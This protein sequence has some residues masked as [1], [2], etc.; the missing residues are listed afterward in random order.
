MQLKTFRINDIA[1]KTV[2][3]RVDYNV[4][5]TK[6]GQV[7]NDRRIQLSLEALRFILLHQAK[8]ILVSHLGR[9]KGPDPKYSLRPIANH[10]QSKYKIPVHFAPEPGVVGP[11]VTD[12]L[13]KLQPGQALLLENLR[14]HPGE[15]KNDPE[16]AAELANL[17]DV[18]INDAFSTAHRAHAS[19]VGVTKYL[20]SLAGTAFAREV[21]ALSEMVGSPRRPF[22]IVLGGAKISD[23]VGAIKHLATMA[24][25]VLVGGAVANNF[26]KAEGIETH[27]SYIE[28]SQGAGG[29]TVDLKK[30]HT[31]YVKFA[32]K[33]IAD[34]K[35]ERTILGGMWPLPKIIYPLDVLAAPSLDTTD[36]KKIEV[37]DLTHDMKDT[38]NDRNL[39]YLDIG[40]KTVKLYQ[41]IISQ[42]KLVFWNGPMGVWENPLFAKGTQAVASSLADNQTG[43]TILGGGDTLAAVEHFKLE[44][45]FA[46]IS[47]AGG[48]ALDF[49]SGITLPGI[50][51]LVLS[52]KD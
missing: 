43:T 20:P 14:F 48:A 27:K 38:P 29:A 16:F 26:L 32:R 34:Y 8:V 39:L 46:Y 4:P 13:E 3:M 7:A 15:K 33:L 30:A 18:Y 36:P 28:D 5:L 23:K 10:L 25:T 42:S 44:K 24:D 2:L 9:P 21:Y 51:P 41:E 50:K 22:T 17:A 52:T 47:A 31:D 19:T 40:P 37:I 12:A 1:H 11:K 35:T 6:D 49:L 45:R